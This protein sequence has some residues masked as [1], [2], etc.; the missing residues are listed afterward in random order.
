[1]I[2]C[3][4]VVRVKQACPNDLSLS[5]GLTF[6]SIYADTLGALLALRTEQAAVFSSQGTLLLKI[7]FPTVFSS[8]QIEFG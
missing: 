6:P 4:G 8:Q 1:M 3:C 7:A 2:L 5:M